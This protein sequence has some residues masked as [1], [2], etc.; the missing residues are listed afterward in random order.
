MLNMLYGQYLKEELSCVFDTLT[1]PK[2]VPAHTIKKFEITD[3]V[4]GDIKKNKLG[5]FNFIITRIFT[6][7]TGGIPLEVEVQ[8]DG[9]I[10]N[11][12]ISIVWTP[13]DV[14]P[15]V[16]LML[17]MDL[18]LNV[19]NDTGSDSD[20]FMVFEGFWVPREAMSNFDKFVDMVVTSV[21][22]IDNQTLALAEARE[23]EYEIMRKKAEAE[24][25]I[26]PRHT[27]RLTRKRDER[28]PYCE[29]RRF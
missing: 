29:R 12:F 21:A 20:M 9:D 19:I 16:P 4:Y 23:D 28:V 15:P 5:T 3:A 18:K 6:A 27:S 17:T 24:G 1:F 7:S 13:R 22:K 10:I 14:N 25:I 11:G 26:M 8:P 2:K